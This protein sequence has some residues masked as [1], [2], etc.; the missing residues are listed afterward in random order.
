VD[1][2]EIELTPS[3]ATWGKSIGESVANID[4]PETKLL[5][6]H[7]LGAPPPPAG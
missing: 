6:T 2:V 4:L 7:A 1:T 5:A 3:S